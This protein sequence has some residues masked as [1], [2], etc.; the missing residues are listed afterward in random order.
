M[1][2]KAS[3]IAYVN[4][5]L[6]L[7]QQNKMSTKLFAE[8]SKLHVTFLLRQMVCGLFTGFGFVRGNSLF[9]SSLQAWDIGELR[10]RQMRVMEGGVTPSP[11]TVLRLP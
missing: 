3:G 1:C 9:H 8:V 10:V 2:V 11:N 5:E 7:P 4:A 6:V